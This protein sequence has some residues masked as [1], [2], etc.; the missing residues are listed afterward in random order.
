[1][2]LAGGWVSIVVGL[3]VSGIIAVTSFVGAMRNAQEEVLTFDKAI[4]NMKE[5]NEKIYFTD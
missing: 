3:I 4:S 2:S 5:S 1:M